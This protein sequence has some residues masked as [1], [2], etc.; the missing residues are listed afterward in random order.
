MRKI[1]RF[2][3]SSSSRF[4]A[5]KLNAAV[6]E[7]DGVNRP[8]FVRVSAILARLEKNKNTFFLGSVASGIMNC[9]YYGPA[10]INSFFS[11]RSST[12]GRT[13]RS[14]FKSGLEFFKFKFLVQIIPRESDHFYLTCSKNQGRRE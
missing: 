9:A 1:S 3:A 5:S 11:S 2:L 10:I 8:L 12:N 6:S 7:T 4:Q 14:S 13:R